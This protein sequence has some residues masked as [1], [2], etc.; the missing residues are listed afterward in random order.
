MEK[1]T[2][3]GSSITVIGGEHCDKLW[4][5]REKGCEVTDWTVHRIRSTGKH[6]LS[7]PFTDLKKKLKAVSYLMLSDI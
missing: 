2:N 4:G 6:S 3:V 7:Q 5:K 1:V